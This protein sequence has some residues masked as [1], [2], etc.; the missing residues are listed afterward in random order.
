MKGCACGKRIYAVAPLAGHEK[1]FFRACWKEASMCATWLLTSASTFRSAIVCCKSFGSLRA[2]I[3]SFLRTC[4]VA[5]RVAACA[6]VG[7]GAS[8]VV[9]HWP[10]TEDEGKYPL[11]TTI[12]TTH[13]PLLTTH[14]PLPTAHYSLLT[15]YHPP[16]TTHYPLLTNHYSPH[17]AHYPLPTTHP[18]SQAFIPSSQRSPQYP[19]GELASLCHTCPGR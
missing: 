3:F 13:H 12:F 16:L 11:L 15:I 6:H 4:N 9:H 17:T 18:N 5:Q 2:K 14:Y 1:Q 10:H 7:G 8:R 19:C